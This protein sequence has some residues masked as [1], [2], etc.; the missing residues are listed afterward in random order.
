MSYQKEIGRIG[1]QLVA[2]WLKANGYIIVKQNF[3]DKYGEIDIIAENPKIIAFV[4]VKTRKENSAVS[5]KDAVSKSKQ[6]KLSKTAK[7]FLN[8]AYMR[9]YPYRFDVAEVTYNIGTDGAPKF[10]LNYIKNA[11]CRELFQD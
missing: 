3:S 11:F 8:R 9:N 7:T 2:D 1:E 6:E 4:E 10:S 5:P